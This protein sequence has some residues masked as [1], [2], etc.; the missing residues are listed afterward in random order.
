MLDLCADSRNWGKNDNGAGH[1]RL[2]MLGLRYPV[3]GRA[4]WAITLTRPSGWTP[5]VSGRSPEDASRVP[6]TIVSNV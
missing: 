4:M 5:K 2:W 1:D 3:G 6:I